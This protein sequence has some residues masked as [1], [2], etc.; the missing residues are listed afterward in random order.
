M[1]KAGL[2]ELKR[3]IKTIKTTIKITR[4]VALAA[5]SKY[6]KAKS[7]LDKS[8]EYFNKFEE[9]FNTILSSIEIPSY[10]GELSVYIIITS[11]SGL[12]GSYNVNVIKS[13]LEDMKDKKVLLITIGEIGRNFLKVKGYDTISKYI[14]SGINLSIKEIEGIVD[15]ILNRLKIDVGEINIV[16]TR[17]YSPLKQMVQVTRLLPID[18]KVKKEY[19]YIEFEPSKEELQDRLIQMY[20]RNRLYSAVLQSAASEHA[21]RMRTMESATKNASEI[22]ENLDKLYNRI[23]QSSI[24][25]EITEIVSGAE[26]MRD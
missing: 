6:K 25:Q 3:R 23:R 14:E 13:A 15:E 26:A 10:L 20:L 17:F 2:I 12:C 9:F 22:L 1:P 5:S 24:T 21:I 4:A 19:G 8:K 7:S 18:I 11:D 16:Y